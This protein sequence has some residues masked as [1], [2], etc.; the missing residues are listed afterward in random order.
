MPYITFVVPCYNSQAYMHRCI[1]SLLPGGCD[2]EIILVDDGS[3]DKTGEIADAYQSLY[4]DIVRTV[5]KSN[6]GHGSGVN[7]GLRLARGLFFK[8][9]DSDDWLDGE[10]YR[11][12]LGYLKKL[13]EMPQEENES[14]P[15]LIISNYFYDHLEEGIRKAV[16]YRNIFPGEQICTW[17][18]LKRFRPSQYLVMHSQIFRTQLL[19]QAQV[20]LPEHTFYVDNL[21][22]CKPLPMVERLVYLDVDL[23][24]YYLGRED[25]SVNEK[26][27]ISR[28]DQ[29][30][31]VTNLVADAV[32]LKELEGKNPKLAVYLRRNISIMMAMTSIHLL[33]MNSPEGY[34][35]RR[36][37]WQGLK[38]RNRGLYCQLRYRTLSG[39]TYLPGRAGGAA[40]LWGYRLANRFLKFQ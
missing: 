15:D 5:H 18:Q 12:L 17:E 16:R 34:E 25:Q 11:R 8:V 14:M 9:V 24:H 6:G 7:T 3:V 35:K 29:L 23:Y 22:S 21:F 13:Q 4:P 37:L 2:V 40:A 33:L 26:V 39:W 10:A 28:I 30:I 27:M 36:T 1:D 38:K 19:R 32:D 31:R 20:I